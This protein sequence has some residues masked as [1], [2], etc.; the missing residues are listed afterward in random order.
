MILNKIM[1]YFS[2]NVR[3]E[4]V[5]G[6]CERFINYCASNNIL[7]VKLKKTPTGF[8]ASCSAANYGAV[9]R[10][11][12]KA[13]VEIKT[14]SKKGFI[15]KVAKYRSRW[16]IA[17]GALIIIAA[18]AVSQ[19]FVFDISVAG[20]ENVR[21]EVILRELEQIGVKKFAYLPDLDLRMKKHE[22]LLR[23][24]DLS[25]L[26]IN[27]SGNK[28]AVTVSERRRQPRIPD[29]SEPCD[30]VAAK[31]GLILFMDVYSGR[32]VV[33]EKHT[34][35]KGDLLIEGS[36][37]DKEG[38][39]TYVH[40]DGRII[41]Q[42]QFEKSLSIDMK[43]YSKDYTG[44]V[45]KQRWLSLAGIK[46]PMFIAFPVKGEYDVEGS[47]NQLI[48]GL[49]FSIYTKS[50]KFYENKPDTLNIGDAREIL[51]KNFMTYEKTELKDS[52][53]VESKVRETLQNGVFT[54]TVYYTC[55]ENIAK[56][57]A[58]Q[59]LVEEPPSK[60]D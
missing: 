9:C 5:N 53:I 28:L 29:I 21:T 52:V 41:A 17:V 45:T 7:I 8:R 26:T 46:I 19:R 54:R 43:Q 23:L 47:E 42:V 14:I 3:F 49:P 56:K 58:K 15:F 1:S 10:L 13:N 48:N 31:T 40:A 2:G 22:A 12:K 27:K 20:N 37:P 16:G 11:A 55:E 50:Y 24:P 44:K 60:L 6:F 36:Y 38:N 39:L 32:K 25:W 30:I 18:L 57:Q 4:A 35:Q 59:L 34:V 51:K 33:T